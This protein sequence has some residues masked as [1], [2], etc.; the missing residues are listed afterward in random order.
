[1]SY[2]PVDVQNMKRFLRSVPASGGWAAAAVVVLL[3][4][5][6]TVSAAWAAPPVSKSQQLATQAKK[7]YD[8][9]QFDRAFDLYLAALRAE[10]STVA[11]RYAA[12]RA[13]HQAGKLDRAEEFYL[14]ALKAPDL[15][16]EL[17][18]RCQ[19][20]LDAI[21]TTRAEARAQEAESLQRAGRYAEAAEVW[22]GAAALQPSR[23]IYLCRAGRAARLAGDKAAA[24]R[25][26]AICRDKA[27]ADT[28]D[29][30]E[31]MRVLQELE[32]PAKASAAQAPQPRPAPPASAA[33]PQPTP[34]AAVPSHA[35]APTVHPPAYFGRSASA[36]VA[37]PAKAAVGGGAALLAAG[38][39]ALAWAASDEADLNAKIDARSGGKVTEI[40][41]EDAAA[42]RDGINVRYGLGWGAVGLGAAA[43]GVGAWWAVRAVDAP[44]RR[45][46]RAILVLPTA[47]GA[48]FTVRF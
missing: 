20:Y 19:T 21:A 23:A 17:R 37:W 42:A 27:P 13:A 43:V 38:A 45:P 33:N 39:G 6:T 48:V 14:Q 22:R 41:Y 44:A 47:S 28:A 31:A 35:G 9:A 12:A 7:A 40:S 26:Y 24:L 30:A 1:M 3:G 32:A 8:E 2:A 11:Y 16:G 15:A 25:D 46:V 29:Y 4:A 18:E 10:P 5:V 36:P 34:P